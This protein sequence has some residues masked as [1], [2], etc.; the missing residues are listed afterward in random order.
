MNTIL[1]NFI[2][3]KCEKKHS[4]YQTQ[5]YDLFTFLKGNRIPNPQHIERLRFSL[6]INGMIPN[7]LLINK[8]FEIIDG[9]HRYE[10]AKKAGTKLYFI[11]VDYK[12]PQVH[13][14]NQDQSNYK[15]MDYMHGFAE[16]GVES[17]VILK[18]FYEKHKVFNP[19][20]CVAM[21]SSVSSNSQYLQ[22]EKYRPNK[23]QKNSVTFNEGT[24]KVR[25]V[26]LGEQWATNLH[27]V[28][29]YFAGYNQSSFVS[30]MIMMF[31]NPDFNFEDFMK[32]LHQRPY[33]LTASAN[34]AQYKLKIEDIYNHRR[35]VR[36]NLRF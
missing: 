32:K 19:A 18:R 4:V 6:Q 24:W 3:E 20:N 13:A 9:Q 1:E 12:L 30:T 35:K 7:P 22:S 34:R 5:D 15:I 17:Y 33:A 25:D 8:E 2:Q 11:I 23:Q 31:K 29:K 26:E 21:L 36:V 27:R 10:A 14:I 28:G 16:T